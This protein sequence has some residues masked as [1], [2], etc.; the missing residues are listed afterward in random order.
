MAYRAEIPYNDLPDLPPNLEIESIAVLKKCI[1]ARAS[2]AELKGLCQTIP[3]AAILIST[4]G[5]QEAR[6]SS[7]IENIVTSTDKLYRAL[8]DADHSVDLSTKEVLRYQEALVAGIQAIKKTPILT[9]SLFVEIA[10]TIKM[11]DL[12]VRKVTGTKIVDG[13]GRA[14]YTPPEGED[15]L[16]QKLHNLE[17]FIHADSSFDPLIKMALIHYQFEAIHPFIDGNG[18][19]GR[20]INILFL[21]QQ[22]LL[23]L[24]VLYL[25][26]YL[27]ENK[28]EYYMRLKNVTEKNEW[29]Q[30][31][32]FILE[33]IER[34]ATA[35]R[36]RILEIKESME[37]TL[38]QLKQKN[39]KLATKELVELLY[40][41]PYCKIRFLEDHLRITRQTAAAYLRTLEEI[42]ILEGIKIGRDVY[43]LNKNLLKILQS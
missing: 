32:L 34:T 36:D 13:S 40:N 12:S 41:R 29:E 17:T 37:N 24:P 2:L 33:G 8:A 19:T 21:L 23:Q 38:D 4:I 11:I 15:V 7:E 6:V 22:G 9:T 26:S 14:I 28:N 42:G 30:W 1:T 31:I 18:R 35:T 16:R 27:I 10:S 20:I 3:N 25:S 43:Y 39:N 5:L